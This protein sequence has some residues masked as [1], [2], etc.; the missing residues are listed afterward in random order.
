MINFSSE[1][2]PRIFP[3]SLP[4]VLGVVSPNKAL[5]PGILGSCSRGVHGCWAEPTGGAIYVEE[6]SQSRRG[7]GAI[8][9]CRFCPPSQFTAP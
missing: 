4:G 6:G 9:N 7:E 1:Q 8:T 2:C 5:P 3:Q